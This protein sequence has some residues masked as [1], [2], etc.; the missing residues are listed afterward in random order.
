MAT[1]NQ[2]STNEVPGDTNAKAAAAVWQTGLNPAT[3][4][5]DGIS[6]QLHVLGAGFAAG[7]AINFDG[8]DKATTVNGPTDVSCGILLAAGEQAR[9]APVFVKSG[10]GYSTPA[11]FKVT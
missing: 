8:V 4:A 10:N 11:P 5:R 7:A 2:G 9:S 1:Y 6:F 3:H